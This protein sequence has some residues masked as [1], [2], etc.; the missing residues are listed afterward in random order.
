MMRYGLLCLLLLLNGCSL[1]LKSDLPAEQ[2]YRLQPRVVH[3]APLPINLYLS[4]VEVSPE[5]D[6][7]RITLIKSPN[8][9]DFIAHSR[10]GDTLSSYLHVVV[11]DA[12]T[13]SGNFHSVSSQLVSRDNNYRLLLRV[14][15][16]QATYPP[17]GVG[18]ASVD[19]AMDALLVR[20]QDQRL[21]GQHHYAIHK[22]NVPVSTSQIVSALEQALSE[23]LDA[24]VRDMASSF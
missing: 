17:E 11:L 8:Q 19:V 21:L 23:A 24:L 9:Q 12:L 3:T 13:R 7:E 1:P 10:W 5:L 15:A 22:T 2:V 6:S 20:V 14:S 4:S 18:T 16:F